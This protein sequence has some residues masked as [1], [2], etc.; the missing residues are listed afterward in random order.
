V[1]EEL[2]LQMQVEEVS[3]L[4]EPE[5]KHSAP[6]SQRQL[7]FGSQVH[8]V[9]LLLQTHP[10]KNEQKHVPLQ[11]LPQMPVLAFKEHWQ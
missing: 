10:S 4:Q 2:E 5:Q 6:D 1:H 3:Q 9:V 7:E 8:G 11:P